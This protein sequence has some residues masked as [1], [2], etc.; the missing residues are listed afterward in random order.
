VVVIGKLVNSSQY[1]EDN[2]EEIVPLKII[3]GKMMPYYPL[4]KKRDE[5]NT[6][7]LGLSHVAKDRYFLFGMTEL[8]NNMYIVSSCVSRLIIPYNIEGKLELPESR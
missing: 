7:M 1:T 3:K 2:Q 8:S 5:V 4:Y 6:G